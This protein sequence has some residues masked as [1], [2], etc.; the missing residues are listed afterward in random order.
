MIDTVM[1]KFHKKIT[2]SAEA[3]KRR[4]INTAYGASFIEILPQPKLSGSSNRHFHGASYIENYTITPSCWGSSNRYCHGV[5]FI[6]ILSHQS[7]LLR[8]EQLILPWGKLHRKFYHI[9]PSCWGSSNRYCHGV[10]YIEILPHQP[11]LSKVEQ[12]ILP[13]GKLHKSLTSPVQVVEGWA[14]DTAMGQA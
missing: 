11:K 4:A 13:W 6:E 14:I 9:S 8:V 5:S 12:S 2:L 3:V 7:K 1:G 10:S